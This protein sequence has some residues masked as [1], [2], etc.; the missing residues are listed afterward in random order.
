MY[1]QLPVPVYTVTEGVSVYS[2]VDPNLF[3]KDPDQKF[4]IRFRILP[5]LI[6]PPEL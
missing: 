6:L 5:I 3:I 4:R 1:Y 2:A